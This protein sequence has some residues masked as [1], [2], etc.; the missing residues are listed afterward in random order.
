M[1]RSLILAFALALAPS[2]RAEGPAD[3]VKAAA[4]KLADAAN[5]SWSTTSPA[6]EGG[7]RGFGGGSSEGKIEKGGAAVLQTTFGDRTNESVIKAGKVAVK[8]DEGWKSG[9]ELASAPRPE[10]GG[11]GGGRGQ[12]GAFAARMAENF[13]APAV[14]AETLATGSKELKKDGDAI[15]GE[16]TEETAKARLTFGGG[17]RGGGGGGGGGGGPA[18]AKGTVKFWVKDGVLAKYEVT[19]GGSFERNGETREFSRTTITEI[20]D[21]GSTKVE[22]PSEAAAKLPAG[23][24]PSDAKKSDAPK[25][26]APKT[27]TPKS[28]A[29]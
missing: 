22:V 19:V 4:K 21:V 12:R 20:K 11:G 6:P 1:K 9:E 18:G 27:E 17:R 25:T 10:G 2:L 23:D 16:L 14:E 13:K 5:Y 8:T 7:N 15:S 29:K 28:D 26:D 24:K 3:E